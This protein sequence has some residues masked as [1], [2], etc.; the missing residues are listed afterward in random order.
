VKIQV[1]LAV[2]HRHPD[3]A[4]DGD[5]I[6]PTTTSVIDEVARKWLAARAS[7]RI[8]ASNLP[9]GVVDEIVHLQGRYRARSAESARERGRRRSPGRPRGLEIATSSAGMRKVGQ[10]ITRGASRRLRAPEQILRGRASPSWKICAARGRELAG[11]IPRC[12]AWRTRRR[13]TSYT[14]RT[15]G[16]PGAGREMGRG[17]PPR[18][19]RDRREHQSPG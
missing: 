14:P 19:R 12:R 16:A 13:A 9:C 17:G 15:S 1:D 4:T 2:A 7:G 5:L 3:V 11:T 18:S 6:F 8:S 10:E